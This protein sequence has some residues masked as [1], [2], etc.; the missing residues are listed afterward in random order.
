MA[1]AHNRDRRQPLADL[2]GAVPAE[3]LALELGDPLFG[4][5]ELRNHRQQDLSR[6][7]RDVVVPGFIHFGGGMRIGTG[8][9]RPKG[10]DPGNPGAL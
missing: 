4:V 8:A 1:S 9:D 5:A 2:V 10:P 3:Q 6:Q 7:R